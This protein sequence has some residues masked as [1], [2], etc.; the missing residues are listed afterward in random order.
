MKKLLPK[1]KYINNDSN[2]P[3]VRI[4]FFKTYNIRNI[5]CFSNEKNKWRKSE[6]KF[7][8]DNEINILLEGKFTTERGRINCSLRRKWIL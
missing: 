4:K 5:N 2:P 1:E 7:L 8:N 6:I 3:N